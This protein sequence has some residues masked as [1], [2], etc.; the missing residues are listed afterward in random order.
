MEHSLCDYEIQAQRL[1]MARLWAAKTLIEE[2]FA[3][4]DLDTG[5]Q[6]EE[7]P[8]YPYGNQLVEIMHQI[9]DVVTRLGN[10]DLVKQYDQAF[11]IA[12]NSKF[13]GKT[14]SNVVQADAERMLGSA[15]EV[16]E[17]I[18]REIQ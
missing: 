4:K 13:Y 18:V 2:A 8:L 16:T 3:Y 15:E 7:Q 17:R 9:T 11:S 14:F 1:T 10:N 6:K 5:L 12:K